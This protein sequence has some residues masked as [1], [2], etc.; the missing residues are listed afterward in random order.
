MRDGDLAEYLY[1][2]SVRLNA[3]YEQIGAP[4][5][6]DKVPIW[7]FDLK[8]TGPT[9]AGSQSRPARTPTN[10][11]MIETLKQYLTKR[12]RLLS[13]LADAYIDDGSSMFGL[14]TLIASRVVIPSASSPTGRLVL[15]RCPLDA[16]KRKMFMAEDLT[17]YL[18]EDTKRD[19]TTDH[20]ESAFSAL[21]ALMTR[22]HNELASPIV[23]PK[24]LLPGDVYQWTLDDLIER[25]GVP[26]EPRQIQC[27]YR[28]R[29]TMTDN[30]MQRDV[31]FGYPIYIK[32][33]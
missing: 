1:V 30:R 23:L 20:Y 5:V 22:L 7:S 6:Y 21:G 17:V 33:S 13:A 18:I 11:E 9:A 26:Q 32:L 14:D 15:W 25:V 12:N 19:G 4:V 3:Y 31:I 29:L 8:L 10:H 2:D 28:V 27:L 16:T 24:H